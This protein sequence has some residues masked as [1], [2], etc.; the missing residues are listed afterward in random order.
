MEGI[1]EAFAIDWRLLLVQAVNFAV[2]LLILWH[3]LYRPLMRMLDER[4]AKIEAGVR[5]AEKAEHELKKIQSQRAGILTSATHEGETLVEHARKAGADK[6]RA[7]LA[8]AE[9]RAHI[10]VQSAEREA[11][12]LKETALEESKV[13]MAKL[14]VLGAERVLHEKN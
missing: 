13:E 5:D 2:L 4:R 6:E 10:L 9:D 7:M 1:I 12:E 8:D 11:R 14:I 3:F